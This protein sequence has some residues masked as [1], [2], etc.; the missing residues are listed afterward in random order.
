MKNWWLFLLGVSL[1][2]S[3]VLAQS[4]EF[5][6][7]DTALRANF[8]SN[9]LATMKGMKADL[10]LLYSETKYDLFHIGAH[11]QGDALSSKGKFNIAIGGRVIATEPNNYSILAFALGARIRFSPM[12]RVGISAMAYYAP[13]IT[14]FS[15]GDRYVET[16]IRGDYQII[17]QAF[18]YVGYRKIDIA[19]QNAP[20]LVI[21][22]QGHLGIKFL[23]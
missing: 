10:G 12:D 19:I 2:S 8:Q 21:E 15:D 16:E 22:D 5:D 6:V 7:H 11:V 20:D 18:V 14:T 9:T 1:T 4:L 13:D 17:P 3:N 23:F